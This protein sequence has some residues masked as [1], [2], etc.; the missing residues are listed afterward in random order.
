M[1]RRKS[2]HAYR[3]IKNNWLLVCKLKLSDKIPSSSSGT[4]PAIKI[5]HTTRTTPCTTGGEGEKREVC[6]IYLDFE[7]FRT[8]YQVFIDFPIRE[9]N[10]VAAVFVD[11]RVGC[12]K[13]VARK[14]LYVDN[15]KGLCGGVGVLVISVD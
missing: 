11:T 2:A 12:G 10:H 14:L 8:S 13:M 5:I 6:I 4:S 7:I 1:L 15:K 9:C 3:I